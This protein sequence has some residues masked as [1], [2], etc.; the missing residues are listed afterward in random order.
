MGLEG[1]Q[2]RPRSKAS[3]FVKTK[4]VR[5]RERSGDDE[6]LPL[7]S[8]G[9]RETVHRGP[10]AGWVALPA[11]PEL[12]EPLPKTLQPWLGGIQLGPGFH[13]IVLRLALEVIKKNIEKIS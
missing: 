2:R 8:K 4:R 13:R 5:G 7:A 1:V 6:G 12:L 3:S 11:V 10:V 9:E